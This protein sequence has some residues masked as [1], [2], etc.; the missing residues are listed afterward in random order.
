MVL[1]VRMRLL[2][3]AAAMSASVLI[4]SYLQEREERED[5]EQRAAE[6]EVREEPFFR[7]MEQ[8]A[9]S[10]QQRLEL[11]RF[12]RNLCKRQLQ[13]AASSSSSADRAAAPAPAKVT[14]GDVQKFA[15]EYQ[16]VFPE[17]FPAQQALEAAERATELTAWN[18]L[19]E[20]T[21]TMLLSTGKRLNDIAKDTK[22]GVELAMHRTVRKY[23]E[24]ALDIVA[25][26]LKTALKDPH[27]PAYL[28]S[29]IDLA[30]EQ[31]MPDVKVE[32][33]RKT[34]ALFRKSSSAAV[35]TN[36]P[37]GGSPRLAPQQLPVLRRVRGHILYHLFP[38]NKSI[39]QSLRDPWWLAYSCVGVFPVVG[40]LWW[41]LLFVLKDKTNEH[42]LC[43]FIVGF[44]VAQFITLGVLHSL[45]GVAAYVHCIAQGSLAL[46]Q[47]GGGPALELWNACFFL[48]QIALVWAAFFRLPYTDRPTEPRHPLT[49]RLASASSV[50][51]ASS[52]SSSA[53]SGK[54]RRVYRDAFGHVL[55]LDR[56]G[57][58][59]KFCG[60]ETASF[61][62][63]VALVGVVLWLPFAPWQRKALFYWVRTAYGL[64]SLPFVAF[65]IPLLANVLLHT[66]R[67]GYNER[68]ETVR[69][70]VVAE[71][72]SE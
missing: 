2:Y 1:F 13:Q 55:H 50:A 49:Y 37:M 54:A 15:Q 36:G 27:M 25:E 7:A 11:R 19:V 70:V 17:L 46:C 5:Q 65:K 42:Q 3:G 72:A 56:G 31:F 14:V 51:T 66:R 69:A 52:A 23:L 53:D 4:F 38:H 59:M 30:I 9:L 45:L 64:F 67:M 60:Y 33:F 34:R 26:R 18:G 40:Q 68:G 16:K 44:K 22:G 12:W 58:L 10:S 6:R 43:Q 32:I 48:L 20:S 28:K 21:S 8:L 71:R 61:T 39:W 24:K 47:E 63:I 62:V 57:Y 29:N 41:L 35:L